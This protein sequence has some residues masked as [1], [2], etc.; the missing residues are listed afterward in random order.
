MAAAR[1]GVL[2]GQIFGTIVQ[3]PYEFGYQSV[4]ILASL[5]R[6]DKTV[7]PESKILDVPVKI[8]QKNNVQAFWD[9]LKNL[10]KATPAKKTVEQKGDKVKIAYLTNNPS[11][12]WKI[13][14]AGVEKAK[15]EFNVDCQFLMPPTGT[16]EEHQRMLEGL[17]TKGVTGVAMSPVDPANQTE[18]I[19]KACDAMNVITQDS[20]APQSNRICYL[21]TNNYNAGRQAGKLIKQALPNGGTLMIFVGM[22]DPQ[23]AIDRRQGIIDEL[24]DKP[25]P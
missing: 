23:N 18:I 20:D 13:A 21:G 10:M 4:R 12:F 3:Q 19:N 9:N 14:R 5:A 25:M 7:I 2:D 8:I 1:Q 17:I 6:G 15:V 22:M 16:A 24:A 11:D